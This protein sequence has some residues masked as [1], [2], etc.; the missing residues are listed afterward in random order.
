MAALRERRAWTRPQSAIEDLAA[1]AMH[2]PEL[3]RASLETALCL[4]LPEEVMRRPGVA[5]KVAE[6]RR[7]QPTSPGPDRAQLLALLDG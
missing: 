3:F 4:A 2:D 6:H 1:A 7:V 5:A